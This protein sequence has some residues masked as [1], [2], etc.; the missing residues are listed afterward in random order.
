MFDCCLAR[1]TRLLW[2]DCYGNMTANRQALISCFF[3]Q[4]KIRVSLH[5]PLNFEPINSDKFE[6]ANDASG[7]RGSSCNQLVAIKALTIQ[8]RSNANDVRTDQQTGT[9]LC[10]PVV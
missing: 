7:F 1:I 4:R 9:N 5:S 10:S 8:H 6:S 2:R 3:K